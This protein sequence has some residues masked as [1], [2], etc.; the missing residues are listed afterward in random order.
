MKQRVE[1]GKQRTERK[2][3][4]N[5]DIIAVYS[6]IKLFT[7]F[8]INKLELVITSKRLRWLGYVLRRNNASMI[9][10]CSGKPIARRPLGRPIQ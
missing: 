8:T 2:I 10:N 6:K 5:P 9:R 3:Y 1:G 7:I 4:I